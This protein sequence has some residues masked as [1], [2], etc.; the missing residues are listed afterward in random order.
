MRSARGGLTFAFFALFK[1]YVLP[2][3]NGDHSALVAH[4]PGDADGEHAYPATEVHHGYASRYTFSL[5]TSFFDPL[6]GVAASFR[7]GRVGS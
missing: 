5:V 1:R 2:R 7:S 6:R 3:I 4:E